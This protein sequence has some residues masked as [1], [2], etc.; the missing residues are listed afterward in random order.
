[1]NREVWVFVNGQHVFNDTNLYQ[2]PAARKVPDGRLWV[3]N[4]SFMLP[5]KTGDNEIAIAIANNFY[6][7]GLILRLDDIEGVRLAHEMKVPALAYSAV[8]AWTAVG[9]CSPCPRVSAAS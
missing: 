2:P 3:Q 6:G 1:M 7:W 5:L 4:G 9:C 8:L